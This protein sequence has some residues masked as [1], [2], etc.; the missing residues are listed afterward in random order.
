MGQ[1]F[2][3]PNVNDLIQGSDIR[4]PKSDEFGIFQ[5]MGEDFGGHFFHCAYGSGFQGVRS[6]FVDHVRLLSGIISP[7]EGC[8]EYTEEDGLGS[9]R[10]GAWAQRNREAQGVRRKG[11]IKLEIRNYQIQ[12]KNNAFI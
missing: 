1:I 10:I 4:V 12:T 5:A 6:H 7:S 8:C 11:K 3:F 2:V 9:R